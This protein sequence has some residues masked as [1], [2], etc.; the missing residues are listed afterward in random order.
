MENRSPGVLQ[1]ASANGTRMG[2]GATRWQLTENDMI[3]SRPMSH[4]HGW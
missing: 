3:V 1:I 4:F 2:V